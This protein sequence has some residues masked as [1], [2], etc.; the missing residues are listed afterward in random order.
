MKLF[1]KIYRIM[2]PPPYSFTAGIFIL[3]S[4]DFYQS[5]ENA[6]FI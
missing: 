1:N 2:L 6:V 3:W 5:S 4:A